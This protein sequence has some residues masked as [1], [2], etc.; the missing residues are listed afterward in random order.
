MYESFRNDVMVGITNVGL[1]IENV[2]M[3]MQVI[4]SVAYNYTVDKRKTEMV[5]YDG[6]IPRLLKMYI[7]SK[8][9]EGFADGTLYNHKIIM[10]KFIEYTKKSIENIDT[11]DIRI[12]LYN[13]QKYLGISCSTL[14]KY[15]SYISAFYKWAY[16]EGYVKHD[17]SANISNIKFE[18]KQRVALTQMDL[19][20]LRNECNNPKDKAIIE[21]LYS[22]GC[23]IGELIGI[24]ISDIDF[25]KGQVT[26]F[27]KG[28]KYRTGFLN[29]KSL[30]AINEY[31]GV[32][33]QESTSEYLFVQDRYPFEQMHSCGI[34]KRIR[35]MSNNI[36]D[37]IGYK[38]VS[39]HIIRHTT[40]TTAINNG[41]SLDN[42]R[43]MLGHENINTTLIY[44][45]TSIEETQYE[46]SKYII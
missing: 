11:N 8:K 6:D 30:F 38:Q 23:R 15:R 7:V 44:A 27:G 14:E 33:P 12:F 3:V 43:K 17:P 39:P 46:H 26:L 1:D 10:M 2:R 19:E 42:I 4:D 22:T 16:K 41:M 31:L 29:A 37:K 9:I 35:I 36:Q 13:Y 32:R 40:A 25:N 5:V 28:K 18:K 21:V 45:K 20:Y 24:K 34:Q